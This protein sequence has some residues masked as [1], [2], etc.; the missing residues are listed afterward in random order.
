MS[1]GHAHDMEA[2]ADGV[3]GAVGFGFSVSNLPAAGAARAA[4]LAL[5]SAAED[6]RDTGRGTAMAH[7]R[8]SE[9]DRSSA[10]TMQ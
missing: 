2:A 3:T 8:L 1:A 4:C 10:G 5:G 6:A 9:A 7:K